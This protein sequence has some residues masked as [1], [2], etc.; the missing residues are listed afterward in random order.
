[1]SKEVIISKYAKALASYADEA[2]T[3][4]KI[5]KNYQD[6]KAFLWDRVDVR[7][8]LLFPGIGKEEKRQLFSQCK[9]YLGLQEGFLK[10]LLLLLE[11]GRFILF[12][13][14]YESFANLY[15]VYNKKVH[16]KITSVYPLTE[17]QEKDITKSLKEI[18]QRK[19]VIEKAI[20]PRLLG[21]VDIFLVNED[22]KINLS[23]KSRLDRLKSQVLG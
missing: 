6:A 8:Y 22:L 16:V 12:A 3:L 20:D 23:L 4:D 5:L 9:E 1:M 15:E 14:I 2:G 21:G 11:E 13:A 18:L 10:F 19:L 7:A 17:E